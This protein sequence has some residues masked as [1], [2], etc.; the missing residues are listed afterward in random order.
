MATSHAVAHGDTKPT[1]GGPFLSSL[2]RL[3][4]E[5]LDPSLHIARTGA[6]PRVQPSPPTL[7]AELG[8]SN[9]ARISPSNPMATAQCCPTWLRHPA[10]RKNKYT[11]KRIS[12]DSPP[13]RLCTH[14]SCPCVFQCD[15]LPT[16]SISP[17]PQRRP[18]RPS[19]DGGVLFSMSACIILA[20]GPCRPSLNRSNPMRRSPWSIQRNRA[21]CWPARAQKPTFS[22]GTSAHSFCSAASAENR[23]AVRDSIRPVRFWGSAPWREC[24]AGPRCVE[25]VAAENRP[26]KDPSHYDKGV[27]SRGFGRNVVPAA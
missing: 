10:A 27:S 20:Q 24:V 9:A 2:P 6:A 12:C 1:T 4:R 5:L 18:N 13:P 21:E 14:K 26:N 23:R 19:R 17:P 7:V 8:K 16:W 25:W 3:R 22:D 15:G 11:P